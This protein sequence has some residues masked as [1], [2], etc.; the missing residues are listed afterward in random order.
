MTSGV[1][2]S[3][4]AV[5]K[6]QDVRRL[7]KFLS[8]LLYYYHYT[9]N[10]SPAGADC[11]ANTLNT[12]LSQNIK[13][14][15]CG[16]IIFISNKQSYDKRCSKRGFRYTFDIVLDFSEYAYNIIVATDARKNGIAISDKS[17]Y[18]HYIIFSIEI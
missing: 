8:S 14:Y 11:D 7:E 12:V 10:T 6:M 2:T 4:T 18:P 13:I 5:E 17:L 16:R 3:H 9:F 1:G 15:N